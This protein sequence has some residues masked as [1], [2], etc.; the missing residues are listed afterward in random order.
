MPTTA[1]N[2]GTDVNGTINAPRHRLGRTVAAALGL[3]FAIAAQAAPAG[4]NGAETLHYGFKGQTAEARF[5]I[6]QGCIGTEA[7]VHAV[8]GRVKAGP[9]RPDAQSSVFV[10]VTRVDIC[11]Q[12]PL[13]FSLG[14]RENLGDALD[15][16]RLDGSSL[17]TTVQ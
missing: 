1:D 12:Q 8:D 14:F 11:T 10:A 6:Q 4:A 15:V 17:A 9:G 3:S 7:S 13:G 5:V 2:G 16:D